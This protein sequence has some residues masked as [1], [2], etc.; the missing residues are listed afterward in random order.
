MSHALGG[1]ILDDV[2]KNGNSVCLHVLLWL[3]FHFH[4]SC[5]CLSICLFPP[6]GLRVINM[7]I[8]ICSAGPCKHS[9]EKA[10]QV[11]ISTHR[12][13]KRITVIL[14]EGSALHTE[15]Q[16]ENSSIQPYCSSAIWH[17]ACSTSSVALCLLPAW[18]SVSVVDDITTHLLNQLP[19]QV[20]C[21]C[22]ACTW[23]HVKSRR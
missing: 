10:G 17:H 2:E 1:T 23:L 13:A 22:V 4:C 7:H 12:E 6:A 20:W 18:Q 16:W 15:P 8:A 14:L 11:S 19:H 3:G 5:F 21:R 9:W